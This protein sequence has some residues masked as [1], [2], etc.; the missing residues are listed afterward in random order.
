MLNISRSLVIFS[1]ALLLAACG[2]DTTGI[3]AE[4]SKTAKG[5]SSSLVTVTEYADLQCPACRSAHQLL[6]EPLLRTYGSRILFAFKHFPLQ[7]IHPHALEA[8]MAAECA[9]DQGSFWEF[10]DI[11]YANQESLN[12]AALR[13]WAADLN[14]DGDLFDRCVRS[15]IKKDVVMEEYAEGV[16]QGVNSTPTY[17]VNGVRISS[18]TLEAI[19]AAI[20]DAFSRAAMS[21][22]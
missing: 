19:S 4:S 11:T 10:I 20:D 3:S 21:P 8:A 16:A 6:N 13:T 5:P 18:N 22:L 7:A 2:I 14:L 15:R 12:S 1:A 17:L 9:A